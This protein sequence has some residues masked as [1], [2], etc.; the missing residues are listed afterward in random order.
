MAL[1]VGFAVAVVATPVAAWL[2]TRVGIVDAPGPLKVHTRPVP[3]LGG[4]AV[5]VALVGPVLGARPSLLVPLGLACALGLLDDAVSVPPVARLAAEMG[6][7]VSAAIAVGHHDFGRV[8]L[9]VV[10]V[11]VLVNA[12]NLLDGLDGLAAGVTIAAA[13]GFYVVLS[14][15]GATTALALV[16][17]ATGFLVWNS[18]P[19]RVYLG[20]SGSYLI[21]TALAM[22]FL[23]AARRPAE[24]VSGAC[25]FL[26]L[27]VADT[28]IAIVRRW[29]AGRPLLAGDRGHVY[30]QLVDRGW[31]APTAVVA[32]VV[33]QAV[34]TG[35]GITI[36]QLTRNAA[37]I[38]TVVTVAIVGVAAILAFT[39]PRSWT[40]R[41]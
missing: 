37:I 16:G 33:A 5:L 7:G 21:G 18:P 4:V 26:A 29:R 40:P 27:P 19:A 22:L 35:A 9:G 20:D 6:I 39:S 34:F 38:V 11:L 13:A 36:A 15:P 30:D 32:C 24:V 10:V 41:Q 14:G 17:A 23:T 1:I 25:L 31:R 2:A 12:V 3:Y 28:T 8:V